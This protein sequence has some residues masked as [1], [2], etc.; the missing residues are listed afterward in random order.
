MT[1]AAVLWRL[2]FCMTLVGW[3]S[4]VRELRFK[5]AATSLL[6]RLSARKW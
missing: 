6:E 3:V 1:I 4:M 2:S 5:R